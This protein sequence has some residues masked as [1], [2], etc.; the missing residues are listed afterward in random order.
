MPTT[1]GRC[2]KLLK[3]DVAKKMWTKEGV[4]YL[5][6]LVDVGDV[7]QDM[8][9]A[10]DPGSKFDGYCV[11]GLKEV[12][13][14]GMAVLPRLVRTRME[15]RR[16]LRHTRRSRNC[17]R[18]QAR[19]DNRGVEV[20]WLAPSQGAKVQLRMRLMARFCRILPIS[21]IVI[22]DVRFNHAKRRW[23]KYFST[24]EIGKTRVYNFARELAEFRTCDGWETAEARKVYDIKKSSTK[25]ELTPESHANDAL[26]M[27]CW[28][29]GERPKVEIC[30]FYIWRRQECSKRQLS[31]T[32]CTKG[33]TRRA[34]GGTTCSGSEV[35]K[36]DVIKYKDG[37]VGYAGGWCNEGSVISLIDG[38]GKRIRQAGKS[39]IEF[40]SFSPNILIERRK[41]FSPPSEGSGF[42][43]K[44]A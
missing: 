39:T 37:T 42:K 6:M 34:Y 23:G 15:T 3:G 2:A 12:V 11:S 32:Q 13:V 29:Y 16:S 18:R 10:V 31:L 5:Q 25:A 22:E 38:N 7:V 36:G 28:L 33:G 30:R 21:D 43:P 24:V 4:F 8:A 44:I 27:V 1:P 20:G 26:A 17:R 9:L 40:L 35:R 14:M 41:G 19:F